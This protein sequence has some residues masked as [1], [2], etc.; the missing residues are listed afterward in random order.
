MQSHVWRD[1]GADEAGKS[2]AAV[3]DSHQDAGVAR[4]DVQ[5]VDVKSWAEEGREGKKLVSWQAEICFVPSSH[6]FRIDFAPEHRYWWDPANLQKCAQSY[7][8]PRWGI[9]PNVP[10]RTPQNKCTLVKL[11]FLQSSPKLCQNFP[12]QKTPG[13]E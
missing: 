1:D 9:S 3:G 12:K 4:G 2:A 10:R 8:G 6:H 11:A 13:D 5:V 7:P